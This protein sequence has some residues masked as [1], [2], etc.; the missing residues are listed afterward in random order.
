MVGDL[1]AG[2]TKYL[3]G[4]PSC[5]TLFIEWQ[6]LTFTKSLS[7]GNKRMNVLPLIRSAYISLLA[8]INFSPSSSLDEKLSPD[9]NIAEERGRKREDCKLAYPNCSIGFLDII[10][11]I[12]D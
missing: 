6:L 5:F 3:I 12:R 2:V 4:S 11:K 1:L 7:A 9:F 10:T 8:F